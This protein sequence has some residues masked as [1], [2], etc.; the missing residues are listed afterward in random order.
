M[1]DLLRIVTIDETYSPVVQQDLENYATI[2]LAKVKDTFRVGGATRSFTTSKVPGRFGG[3]YTQDD[4]MENGVV[5]ATWLVKG[6][7]VDQALRRVEDMLAEAD[8]PYG[9][10]QAYIQWRPENA[11]RTTYYALRG[12]PTYAPS[13]NIAQARAGMVLVD[14]SW[15]VAPLAEGL[16]MSWYDDFRDRGL[17]LTE[18]GLT[19]QGWKHTGTWTY[20]SIAS[21]NLRPPAAISG[22]QA[23]VYNDAR[24]QAV[25]QEVVVTGQQLTGTAGATTI[26]AG[27]KYQP[28]DGQYLY[29]TLNS[30]T[31]ALEIRHWDGA[32][33]QLKATSANNITSTGVTTITLP[34][35]GTPYWIGIRSDGITVYGELWLAEPGNMPTTVTPAIV[36]PYY[37]PQAIGFDTRAGYPVLNV[38]SHATATKQISGVRVNS[39][40]YKGTTG[41]FTGL[42]PPFEK[43]IPSIPGTAPAL[44]DVDVSK[45]DASACAFGSVGWRAKKTGQAPFGT[46]EVGTLSVTGSPTGG[47]FN[48][49]I[50]QATNSTFSI[51]WNATADQVKQAISGSFLNPSQIIVTG[52]PLPGSSVSIQY[53]GDEL[54]QRDMFILSTGSNALTGGTTPAPSYVTTTG[55]AYPAAGKTLYIDRTP[56]STGFATGAAPTA[57]LLSGGTARRNLITLWTSQAAGLVNSYATFDI[58]TSILQP[59]PFSTTCLVSFYGRMQQSVLPVPAYTITLSSYPINSGAFQ[60]TYTME[61][62]PNGFVLPQTSSA[63]TF[64]VYSLGTIALP[65]NAGT[66]TIEFSVSQAAS[67]TGSIRLDWLLGMPTLRSWSSPSGKDFTDVTYPTFLPAVAGVRRTVSA[68][69]SSG[70]AN[71]PQSALSFQQAAGIG[72]TTAEIDPGPTVLTYLASHPD[73]NDVNISSPTTADPGPSFRHGVAL[74]VTP[75]YRLAAS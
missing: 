17:G 40:S 30:S 49:I 55:G 41:A 68:A 5:A 59:D 57:N 73:P 70:L 53:T 67:A 75:R 13:Y 8:I 51:P 35:T 10:D 65:V 31:G 16:R 44:V 66:A 24:E 36:V 50:E 1:A 32:A 27:I 54:G 14:I 28:G 19:D 74:G 29:A 58:D 2:G 62:G 47:S 34:A 21:R 71:T 69:L 45:S 72:G 63:A 48:M 18:A 4:S 22:Q 61:Y 37:T 42:Q 15:P 52:G 64:R 11:T 38:T 25:D 56:T 33:S 20:T 6:S 39:Y 60:R 43:S 46:D 9:N 26:E 23:V 3:S 7:T 12:T